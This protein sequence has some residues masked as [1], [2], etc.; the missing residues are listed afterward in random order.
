M[1]QFRGCHTNYSVWAQLQ[2]KNDLECN[3]LY[4]YILEKKKD[5][6]DHTKKRLIHQKSYYMSTMEEK[7]TTK[8]NILLINSTIF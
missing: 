5:C 6:Y 2:N 1:S 8:E 4:I 7:M 3:K